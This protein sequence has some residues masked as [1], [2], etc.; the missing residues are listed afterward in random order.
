MIDKK[1]CYTLACLLPVVD[2]SLFSP[3]ILVPRCFA[4]NVFQSSS[5]LSSLNTLSF[6]ISSVT[7]IEVIENSI[8]SSLGSINNLFLCALTWVVLV[9]IHRAAG[10]ERNKFSFLLFSFYLIF[11]STLPIFIHFLLIPYQ[12]NNLDYC[13]LFPYKHSIFFFYFF[14]IFFEWINLGCSLRSSS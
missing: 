4:Q 3:A 13:I 5:E 8:S 2:S 9:S 12:L 10:S 11:L 14:E 7:S 6:E 1:I